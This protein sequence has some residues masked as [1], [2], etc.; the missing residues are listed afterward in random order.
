MIKYNLK[1][2]LIEEDELDLVDTSFIDKYDKV[3]ASEGQ[4]EP[5]L[6]KYQNDLK[7]HIRGRLTDYVK[8]NPDVTLEYL[9]F[10]NRFQRPKIKYQVEHGDQM[11]D[12]YISA[13]EDT[14]EIYDDHIEN[15][16]ADTW[17]EDFHMWL[18]S[19]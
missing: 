16:R 15:S 19:M 12:H 8:N 4:D 10:R 6:R 9:K 2:I 1:W 18:G 14:D 11:V 13:W 3:P 17:I 5:E 7:K